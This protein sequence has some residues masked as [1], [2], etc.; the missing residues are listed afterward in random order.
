MHTCNIDRAGHRMSDWFWISRQSRSTVALYPFLQRLN[1]SV[2]TAY[3]PFTDFNA[4]ALPKTKQA[5]KDEQMW[6]NFAQRNHMPLLWPTFSFTHVCR[7]K[8]LRCLLSYQT[9]LKPFN[10]LLII[11]PQLRLNVYTEPSF[12]G[13][14]EHP[15]DLTGNGCVWNDFR[16]IP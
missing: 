8:N 3:Q 2:C 15:L 9:V 11:W 13:N 4:L 16:S 5:N 7:K 10:K 6:T 1:A 12:Q 14:K